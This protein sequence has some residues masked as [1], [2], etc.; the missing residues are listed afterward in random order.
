MISCILLRLI[1]HQR[2]CSACVWG[3]MSWCLR[4]LHLPAPLFFQITTR[5]H[6]GG[7]INYFCPIAVCNSAH[8]NG[9]LHGH[10]LHWPWLWTGTS[11]PGA[12]HAC[13]WHHSIKGQVCLA[14]GSLFGWTW[15]WE[16]LD[17]K[18][19]TSPWHS[20]DCR[21]T[22]HTLVKLSVNLLANCSWRP[23]TNLSYWYGEPP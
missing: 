19:E 4:A 3:R 14:L 22:R 15:L 13:A 10:H 11:I 9:H 8:A 1:K 7:H 6:Y 16:H 18:L 17:L 5:G 21:F 20:P 2:G 23:Y 12:C